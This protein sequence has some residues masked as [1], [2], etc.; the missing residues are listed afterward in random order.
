MAPVVELEG[1]GK[2]YWKLDEQAMLLR[3]VLPFARPK[4]S[5]FWALREVSYGVEAGQTLGILGG[6]GAGKT[7][8]LR[9]LAGVSRPS[10]GRLTVRGRVAPLI[11]VGVGF[12]QEM[13]GREN[14]LVNGMLLGLS[15]AEVDRR[16][17]DIVEFAELAHFIDTPVKFYSSGMFMRLGF[18]VAVHVRPEVLL[19]DEVLAVGDLSFQLKCF[20]R[21]RQLRDDGTTI[22]LVSHSMHAIR[23]LCQ[24]AV[25]MRHGHLVLDGPVEAAIAKH[26]EL[27]GETGGAGGAVEILDRAL[28]GDLEPGEPMAYRAT[29]RFHEAVDSPQLFF[30]VL[31][32]D[33][34]VAYEVRTVV[35]RRHRTF[36]AGETATVEV[37]FAQHLAGG[38]Y[39]LLL[40]VVSH[41]ARNVLARDGDGRD[42]YVAP[43]RRTAR[44]AHHRAT[45]ARGGAVLSDHSDVVL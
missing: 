35:N 19:V 2:R 30:T 41:D 14:V 40:A 32:E 26:H 34:T 15:R 38:S 3:S 37:R 23:L 44:G 43:P 22:L 45:H 13:T 1:V 29:L 17:D 7:T 16:F 18:S 5:E 11:G 33:G 12:H 28:A 6:N 31:A 10:A 24:R 8:M 4:R 20:E 9:L 42:A 39:R 36:A 27:L 21:M 25:V